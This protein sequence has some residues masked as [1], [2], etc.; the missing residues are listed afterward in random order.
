MI[1]ADATSKRDSQYDGSFQVV[2]VGRYAVYALVTNYPIDTMSAPASISITRRLVAL[3]SSFP[4]LPSIDVP[5][6]ADVKVSA[7]GDDG[8]LDTI[9]LIDTMPSPVILVPTGTV[10]PAPSSPLP[11]RTVQMF[12]SDGASFKSLTPTSIVVP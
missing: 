1:A 12:Q 6:Q 2:G 11:V 7:N 10:M 5:L 4:A 8:A 3:G 9:A